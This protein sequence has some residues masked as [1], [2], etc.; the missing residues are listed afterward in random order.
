MSLTASKNRDASKYPL[1]DDELRGKGLPGLPEEFIAPI[2]TSVY[3]IVALADAAALCA[4]RVGNL[5]C[6]VVVVVVVVVALF[7]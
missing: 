5:T 1:D 6:Y 7:A 3:I 2:N 4:A